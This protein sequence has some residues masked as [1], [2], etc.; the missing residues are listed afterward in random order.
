MTFRNKCY[1]HNDSD[2]LVQV[3]LLTGEVAGNSWHVATHQPHGEGQAMV[4]EDVCHQIH[5]VGVFAGL[6][7]CCVETA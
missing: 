4:L 5:M 3:V 7:G 6:V 2:I 1:L